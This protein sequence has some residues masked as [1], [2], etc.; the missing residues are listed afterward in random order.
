MHVLIA[1]TGALSP[2]LAVRFAAR[3]VGN[4]GRVTV[5]TI[6]EVPRSFL[7]EIR[8]D[9]WHPLDESSDRT[10]V[11]ADEATIA[12]YL[13]ERGTRL[14]EPVV[15]GLRSAGLDAET[16][17]TEGEDPVLAISD[18]AARIGADVVML[19]ATRQLFDQTA[20][21]SVSARI[22][23]ESGKPVLV[24]PSEAKNHQPDDREEIE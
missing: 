20:W 7:D 23:I 5:T 12:L 4:D 15:Q 13:E 21:E 17:F 6:V 9:S 14:T 2:E 24:L 8:G 11:T 16:E 10:L 19:G 1:T 3:L 22:M 18:L